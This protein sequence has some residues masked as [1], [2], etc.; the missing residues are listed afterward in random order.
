MYRR[1]L[2]QWNSRSGRYAKKY[3]CDHAMRGSSLSD[4]TIGYVATLTTVY[5][6]DLSKTAITD[7]GL[8]SFPA[9]SVL[10]KLNLSETQITAKGL[11][12]SKLLPFCE[13]Q[14]APGQF[15]KDELK[16]LR[17]KW[18]VVVADPLHSIEE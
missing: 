8:A 11:M 17:T 14:V 18:K 4:E 3:S 9:R 10:I 7:A 12:A 2:T 1:C 5:D 6:M 13:I 16:M 15:T